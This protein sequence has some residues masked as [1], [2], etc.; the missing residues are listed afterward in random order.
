MPRKI[1]EILTGRSLVT[2]EQLHQGL[3]HQVVANVR[4]GT[5]LVQLGYLQVDDLGRCLSIQHGVPLADAALLDGATKKALDRVAPDMCERYM[6]I[7]MG[8]EDEVL[9]LAMAKPSRSIAGELSFALGLTINRFVAPELRV[10]YF[11]ERYYHVLRPPRFL[12]TP[13]DGR[14]D[15]DRRKYL[16][17]TVKAVRTPSESVE[18]RWSEGVSIIAMGQDEEPLLT[19]DEPDPWEC[20]EGVTPLPEMDETLLELLAK[21]GAAPPPPDKDPAQE[22]PQL[23]PKSDA[24]EEE[25]SEARR[26]TSVYKMV[27]AE[28]RVDVL[29]EKLDLAETTEEIDRL[30]VE[31]FMKNTSLSL[32]FWIRDRF[33]IGSRGHGTPTAV[34]Q[35]QKLVVTLDTP[36][37]MRYA[38]QTRGIIRGV[39]EDDDA[40]I[41]IA[42]QLD[43]PIPGE[44]CITPLLLKNKVIKLLCIHSFPNTNF[45]DD[46][47][48]QVLTL[49]EH[50]AAAYLRT[51][52]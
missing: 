22:A 44:I 33:A 29:K 13:D 27:R 31:P 45:P 35:P 11:L 4:I 19:L 24:E 47:P 20:A 34:Q 9:N 52:K 21:D 40:Q 16:S 49:V 2:V 43:S 23:S 12:R 5:A 50:A 10:V 30:L 46:A 6:I 37:M 38:M 8:L 36:S 51:S 17:A 48:Q 14:R 28:R 39:G 1:G 18:Q 42:R 7:P 25:D 3:R 41:K 15:Q 32:L 26:P